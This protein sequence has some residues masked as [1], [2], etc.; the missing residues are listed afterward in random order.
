MLHQLLFDQKLINLHGQLLGPVIDEP[1]GD[2]ALIQFKEAFQQGKQYHEQCKD[3]QFIGHLVILH[4]PVD[5]VDDHGEAEDVHNGAYE[6]EHRVQFPGPLLL[7]LQRSRQIFEHFNHA[8]LPQTSFQPDGSETAH[9]QSHP[10]TVFS[11][12]P[13]C[14]RSIPPALPFPQIP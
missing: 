1:V 8:F 9:S 6:T 13:F 2:L 11:G 7:S 10:G 5:D 3:N 12:I 14:R 4:H